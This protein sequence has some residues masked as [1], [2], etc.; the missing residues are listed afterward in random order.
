MEGSGDIVNSVVDFAR[1]NAGGVGRCVREHPLPVAM[2]GAGLVWLALDS[3]SDYSDYDDDMDEDEFGE[4]RERTTGRLRQRAAA[5]G[6]GVRERAS[7]L[8][9]RA[10]AFGHKART[11][12][13]RAG[14]SGEIGRAHV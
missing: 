4:R 2:I 11:R 9:E 14:R 5:L 10:G 8:G 1:S 6:E 13:S 7:D 3:R 12:V